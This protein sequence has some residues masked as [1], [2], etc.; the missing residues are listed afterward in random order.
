VQDKRCL[1]VEAEFARVLNMTA[2]DGNIL[3]A[4]I[5]DA[6]DH[7]RLRTMTRFDPLRATGAHI[8]ADHR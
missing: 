1:V 3:S 2:R 7:G 5:R 8:R 6:W 4:V